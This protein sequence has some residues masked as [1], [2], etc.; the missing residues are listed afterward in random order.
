MLR[1]CLTI[2]RNQVA[3]IRPRD[4]VLRYYANAADAAVS[5]LV[6]PAIIRDPELFSGRDDALDWLDAERSNLVAAA[7]VTVNR[8]YYALT[9]GLCTV[10]VEYLSWRRYIDDWIAIATIG[11]QAARNLT[12]AAMRAW[13]S[14]SWALPS[15]GRDSST[16]RLRLTRA[17]QLFSG[18]LVTDTKKAAPCITLA[19]Y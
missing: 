11:L 12:T 1:S 17:L 8:G 5:H 18:R 10:L 6:G 3:E 7:S 13:P 15:K 16:K 14:T 4:R 19:W 9:F 2:L